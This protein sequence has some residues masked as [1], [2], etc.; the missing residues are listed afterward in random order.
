MLSFDA[1]TAMVDLGE[2]AG[3]LIKRLLLCKLSHDNHPVISGIVSIA[4]DMVDVLLGNSKGEGREYRALRLVNGHH[5][6]CF[7]RNG[8]FKEVELFTQLLVQ[9]YTSSVRIVS[10]ACA[11][12][13]FISPTHCI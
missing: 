12:R 5:L 8:K 2:N 13:L 11:F 3:K 9:L 4:Q 10:S 7:G 6:F 1:I